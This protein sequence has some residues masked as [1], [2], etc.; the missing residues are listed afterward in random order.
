MINLLSAQFSRLLKNKFFYA[1]LIFFAAM[2]ALY[3]ALNLYYVVLNVKFASL[4]SDNESLANLYQTCI[5]AD[6]LMYSDFYVFLI[7]AALLTSLF[8][9]RD[10]D[11]NTVRNQ[12]ITGHSRAEIYLSNLI[13]CAASQIIMHAVYCVIIFIPSF[14][15]YMKFRS[16]DYPLTLFQNSFADNVVIQLIGVGIILAGTSVYLFLTTMSGSRARAVTSSILALFVM[17]ILSQR[18]SQEM[19]QPDE[20]Q[21]AF[22]YEYYDPLETADTPDYSYDPYYGYDSNTAYM[23]SFRGNKL[24]KAEFLI[25]GTIDDALPTSH[26]MYTLNSDRLPPRAGKYLLCDLFFSAVLNACGIA[27]FSRR[28]LK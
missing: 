23:E 3:T 15:V 8:I 28:D 11:N 26:A 24:S 9:G 14:I 10:L 1:S 12:V 21:D 13:V 18:A 25:F 19:Y 4:V 6:Q 16:T 7:V 17:I 2:G 22:V 20:Y 27:V 5:N